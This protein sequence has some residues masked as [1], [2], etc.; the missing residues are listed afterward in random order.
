M[1]TTIDQATVPPG[2]VH[3]LQKRGVAATAESVA[4]NGLF[5]EA[6]LGL[7]EIEGLVD[8]AKKRCQQ[9]DIAILRGSLEPSEADSFQ[10]RGLA[11]QADGELRAA[12]DAHKTAA[13]LL[14]EMLQLAQDGFSHDTY[15]CNFGDYRGAV[16]K[17]APFGPGVEHAYCTKRPVFGTFSV[18]ISSPSDPKAGKAAPL[19]TLFVQATG[20]GTLAYLHTGA[21]TPSN[22]EA[23]DLRKMLP[24]SVVAEMTEKLGS[25]A[26]W[27]VTDDRV[28]QVCNTESWRELRGPLPASVLG[29]QWKDTQHSRSYYISAGENGPQQ[30]ISNLNGSIRFD[31]GYRDAGGRWQGVTIWRHS[32]D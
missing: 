9:G 5:T 13:G 8:V 4:A 10:K 12:Q 7:D 20:S 3:F 16:I 27:S 22:M 17:D 21:T 30:H 19:A 28:Q 25:N 1:R 26:I 29:P 15:V 11:R 18:D 32:Y 24:A 31:T 23:Q 14:K 2:F 6:P